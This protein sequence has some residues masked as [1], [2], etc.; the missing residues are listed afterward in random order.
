MAAR[1]SKLPL[2]KIEL[3]NEASQRTDN[4]HRTS[5]NDPK[6]STAISSNKDLTRRS[7]SGALAAYTWFWEIAALIFS[8]ACLV[9]IGGILRAYQGHDVPH[10]YKGLTLNTIISILAT[11]SKSALLFAVSAAI[12]QLKWIWFQK[13]PRNL[14]DIVVFDDASRGPLGEFILLGSLKIVLR[15]IAVVGATAT[16]LLL[17]LDPFIQ[18]LLSYSTVPISIRSD[19]VCVKR[20]S[21]FNESLPGLDIV[22]RGIYSDTFDF[23]LQPS[24]DT[25]NC[26]W[27]EYDSIAWCDVCEKQDA[28][29]AAL[30]NCQVSSIYSDPESSSPYPDLRNSSIIFS[31]LSTAFSLTCD[32]NYKEVNY[33]MPFSMQFRIMPNDTEARGAG[34]PRTAS[35]YLI[36]H[37]ERTIVLSGD[38]N[39]VFG[40]D[41]WTPGTFGSFTNPLFAFLQLKYDYILSNLTLKPF[42]KEV[43]ECVLSPCINRNI[44]SMQ[45]GKV[46]P[47][48]DTTRYGSVNATKLE[49]KTILYWAAESELI[50]N[51]IVGDSDITKSPPTSSPEQ[52]NFTWDKSLDIR[53]PNLNSVF[54]GLL[55][56]LQGEITSTK[57]Y[58]KV[59]SDNSTAGPEGVTLELLNTTVNEHD[60]SNVD[61]VS[62]SLAFI[63]ANGGLKNAVRRVAAALNNA[64]LD[65]SVEYVPGKSQSLHTKV[66]VRPLWLIFPVF[67]VLLCTVFVFL[68]IWMSL[69]NSKIKAW[70]NSALPLLYHGLDD[71][72]ERDRSA[73]L[74]REIENHARGTFV[75]LER[76]EMHDT[77]FLHKSKDT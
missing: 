35:I 23:P 77:L 36:T 76:H 63:A 32:V 21:T 40:A 41:S 2:K 59:S 25:G 43:Q 24:C 18:Q 38:W 16:I 39:F 50:Q 72:S 10:L 31:A 1:Y 46:K 69:G 64:T 57:W 52:T 68:T 37:E 30:L 42:I 61:R 67:L 54:D 45:A 13:S 75:Q 11:T 47:E 56:R 71:F 70:K 66:E 48:T 19:S 22:N 53:I 62:E 51:D 3:P 58:Y 15:S 8:A 49:G 4:R 55:K 34:V 33:T 26:T 29:Q 60:I 12:G 74:V 44:V 65:N 7:C 14:Y 28:T 6:D 9:A 5:L 20:A 73:E 27:P 17:G